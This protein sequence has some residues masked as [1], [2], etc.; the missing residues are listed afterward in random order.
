MAT[1]NEGLNFEITGDASGYIS[2]VKK[3]S[4]AS[5]KLSK[6]GNRTTQVM[7]QLS[8][9][10]DDAQY[11]FRGVQNNLQAVAV[12]AGAGGP[13]ILGITVLLV[14]INHFAEAW[15]KAAREAKQAAELTAKALADAQGPIVKMNLYADA[16]KNAEKGTYQYQHALQALKKQGFDPVNEG[17]DDFVTKQTALI[18]LN[19]VEAATTQA[20]S[21]KV[22]EQI[23]LRNKLNIAQ[24]KFGGFDI[25]DGKVANAGVGY[26]GYEIKQLQAQ[27][28]RIKELDRQIEKLVQTGK[29][30]AKELI[31]EGG[32]TGDDV[33]IVSGKGITKSVEELIKDYDEEIKQQFEQKWG[34]EALLGDYDIKL[35]DPDSVEFFSQDVLDELAI[36]EKDFNI[37]G[38]GVYTY[39]WIS[40]YMNG[41]KKEIEDGAAQLETA[42]RNGLT[43]AFTDLGSGIGESLAGDG[44]F[45]DKFIQII[46][47]FMVAF[48]GAMVAIGVAKLKLDSLLAVPG[49]A[50][51]II[52]GGVALAA[53]GSAI[54]TSAGRKSSGYG[55]GGGAGSVSTVGTGPNIDPNA[56]Q[57]SGSQERIVGVIRG[58]DLRLIAQ[59]ADDSYL[60][61]G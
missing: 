51:A 38:P 59:R 60:A 19:A 1:T 33:E 14:A 18:K 55:A 57:S 26:S 28:D 24:G 32:L 27:I 35:F 16:I 22:A 12:Q 4:N 2:A 48:G 30:S 61:L 44:S 25:I 15:Q 36:D 7:T 8:Y 20:V 5:G 41:A 13:L 45:G 52:A 54:A 37:G 46:G 17:I 9:A 6:S 39:G 29:D 56:F 34:K 43:N 21:K 42:L 53:V 49:A 40:D 3:A 31:A 11:G 58:Q 10:L 50:P 23:E 47:K